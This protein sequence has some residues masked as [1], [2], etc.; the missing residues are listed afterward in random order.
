MEFIP[1]NLET[2]GTLDLCIEFRRDAHIVSFGDDVNF[3]IRE[4]IAWFKKLDTLDN[5]G[6]YHV[7]KNNEIIGQIEFR[8]GLLDDKGRKFGYINLL[9]LLPEFRNKGIGNK[10]VD[11]IF[12]QFKNDQCAYAQLRYIPA[13]LSAVSFYHKHGW[14]DI[15]EMKDRGQLAEKRLTV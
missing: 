8:H 3:N 12:A 1:V 15:G 10:L 11:F 4:T 14:A 9:Y 6:F 13:N 5:S 2:A 7:F